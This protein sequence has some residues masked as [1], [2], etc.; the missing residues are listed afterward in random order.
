MR[1]DMNSDL[2][3]HFGAWRMG[4][5]AAMLDIVTSANIACGFHAGDPLSIR[6]TVSAAAERGVV[7]GAHV[8]YP[9]LV[10][11]GRRPMNVTSPELEADVMYQIGALDGLARS[12]GSSVAYVKPH[13]ALYNTIAHDERQAAAVIAAMRAFN[14]EIALMC[15]A[16]TPIVEQARAAGLTVVTEAFADRGYEPD[17]RLVSRREEGAVLHDAAEVAARMV[18]LVTEG[19]I[20]AR[21]GSTVTLQADSICVHGD[22]PGA[23]E[24]ARAVRGALDEAGVVLRSFAGAER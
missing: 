3:E 21:D 22:S 4:D 16:G 17:G 5:D 11:F 13:G 6:E 1:I 2:G 10:G 8:A 18:R 20:E 7:I 15:L 12:C 23:L 14:P 9:D 19:V 24:M